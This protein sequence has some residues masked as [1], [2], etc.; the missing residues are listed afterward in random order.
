MEINFEPVRFVIVGLGMGLERA[1]QLRSDPGTDVIG[2]VDLD[3]GKAEQAARE[4]GCGW[5]TNLDTWLEDDGCEAVYVMTPTGTHADIAV[6]S[7][8]AGRHVLT[9]KP[10]EANLAACDRMIEAADRNSRLLAVDFEL[11]LERATRRIRQYIAGGAIGRSLGGTMA[12][13]IR[14][15]DEYYRAKGGWRGTKRLDGG[16]VMSNQA[17]H[18]IDQLVYFLGMPERV[19]M[20]QWTQTHDIEAE[21]LGCATWEYQEGA[22]V[23]IYATTTYP[24]DTWYLNMELHGTDGTVQYSYGGP[25]SEPKERWNIGGDWTEDPSEPEMPG[26]ASVAQN[27]A[28]S[29]RVGARQVCDGRDGRRSRLVLDRMYESAAR[30]GNWVSVGA[31]E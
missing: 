13:R 18:H 14:R 11:R 9:T 6:A 17:I 30:D 19:S 29:I 31:R 1:R 5:S 2:V 23:Q 12:L 20:R 4:L 24:V 25:G 16:G 3:A 8:N 28:A 10:M 7:L 26:W 22:V 21:D 27:L 15:D